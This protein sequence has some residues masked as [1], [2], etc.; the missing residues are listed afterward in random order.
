MQAV[1]Q[2]CLSLRFCI[3]MN[4]GDL[5]YNWMWW[6]GGYRS[7][8]RGGGGIFYRGILLLLIIIFIV[9]VN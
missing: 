3:D 1:S 5:M 7:G 6:E 8:W 4:F 9:G 2:L